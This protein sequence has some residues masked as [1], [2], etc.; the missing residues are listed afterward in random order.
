[1]TLIAEAMHVASEKDKNLITCDMTFYGVID[2]I[3]VVDYYLL[4]IPLLQ[5]DWVRNSGGV[6]NDEHGFIL[7]DLNRLGYNSDPFILA[8]Q[9]KQVFYVLDQVEKRWSLVCHMPT[10]GDPNLTNEHYV[11]NT[12]EHPPF[13]TKLRTNELLESADGENVIYA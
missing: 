9:A 4:K 11:Q 2:E 8:S 13:T 7:V 3:W 6:K 1:M 10:R 5:C 12:T